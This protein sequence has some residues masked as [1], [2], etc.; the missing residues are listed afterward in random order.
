MF[1]YQD[2]YKDMIQQATDGSIFV[3]IGS[4][5]GKSAAFMG[6]E[7]I[8]S[9]KNIQLYCVDP[10]EFEW[11]DLRESHP[12]AKFM[13]HRLTGE[14]A[15]NTFKRSIKPYTANVSY[16]KAKSVNASKLFKN[17]SIDF[18]FIDG[19]HSYLGCYLDIAC[20]YKKVKNGGYLA[21][22]DFEDE[23]MPGVTQA[24][25]D[26]LPRARCTSKR[27]WIYRRDSL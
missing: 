9:G 18:V 19:D 22:H 20:W 10:W 6:C 17:K 7:I 8:N 4:F 1:D 5:H 27:C 25:E 12:L 3:E 21:G 14:H 15:F 13:D 23:T 16:V 2:L 26:L 24:V 11:L